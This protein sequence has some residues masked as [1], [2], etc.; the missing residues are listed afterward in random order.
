MLRRGNRD[1]LT[2]DRKRYDRILRSYDKV[3]VR[4][5]DTETAEWIL[6]LFIGTV[7]T[8]IIARAIISI[9]NSIFGVTQ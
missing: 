4:K 7:L 5:D 3:Q 8:I 6:V 9:L 1:T 2:A